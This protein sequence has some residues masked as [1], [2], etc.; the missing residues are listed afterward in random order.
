MEF[1]DGTDEKTRGHR[2]W[3][4]VTLVVGSEIRP[5]IETGLNH[6]IMDGKK[7]IMLRVR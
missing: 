6:D 1:N 5:H 4:F 7:I 3:Y 2:G